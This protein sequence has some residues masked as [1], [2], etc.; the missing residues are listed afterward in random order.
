MGGGARPLGGPCGERC[1]GSMGKTDDGWVAGS[2]GGQGVGGSMYG[3]RVVESQGEVETGEGVGGRGG[4]LGQ[5]N[6][7]DEHLPRGVGG[8]V[9]CGGGGGDSW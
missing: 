2:A 6:D 3:G 5:E 7:G 9:D 4:R 1:M 8:R